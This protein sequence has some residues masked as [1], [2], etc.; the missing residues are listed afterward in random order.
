[1]DIKSAINALAK[2]RASEAFTEEFQSTA[3]EEALIE[4][5]LAMSISKWSDY[6]GCKIMRVFADALEDANFHSEAKTV[7]EWVNS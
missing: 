7:R 6:D 5:G 3:S 2:E 4:G 1:M